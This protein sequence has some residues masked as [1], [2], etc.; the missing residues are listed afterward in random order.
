M[1]TLLAH[2]QGFHRKRATRVRVPAQTFGSGVAQWER[3]PYFYF[4][5]FAVQSSASRAAFSSSA[6]DRSTGP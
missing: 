3:A 6:S 4:Q 1:P 5:F 2:D